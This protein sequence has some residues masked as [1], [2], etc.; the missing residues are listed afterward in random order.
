MRG[1]AGKRAGGAIFP[2]GGRGGE[3]P[4]ARERGAVW[5][6]GRNY[7][8]WE[9]LEFRL[10]ILAASVHRIAPA[11]VIL[12]L[13]LNMMEMRMIAIPITAIAVFKGGIVFFLKGLCTV[14]TPYRGERLGSA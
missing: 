12:E 3:A 11:M 5:G 1:G 6:A 4:R 10:L 14:I 7:V 2:V 13:L 8:R 9:S